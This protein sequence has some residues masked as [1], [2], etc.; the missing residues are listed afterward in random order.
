MT[1]K[2]LCRKCLPVLLSLLTL[3]GG[4]TFSSSAPARAEAG[5]FYVAPG[6]NCGAASPCYS[7][8]QAAVDA[9]AAGDEIRVATGVYSGV[10]TQ[11][12][13]SQVVYLA[14]DLSLR[15]GFTTA[16][17]TAPD[18]AANPTEI[19]AQT[20]G[21]ALFVAENVTAQV[22]G[23]L[24]TYGNA[25][26]L[27][28]HSDLGGEKDAGGGIYLRN[29]S[30]TLLDSQVLHS[31][32]TSTGLGGGLYAANSAVSVSNT[33]FE[34]NGS[35]NGGGACL[36]DSTTDI[37]DS[38]FI[39]NRVFSMNATGQGVTAQGGNFTFTGNTVDANINSAGSLTDGSLYIREATFLV[40]NNLVTNTI[41]D[42]TT[43]Y[44]SGISIQYASGTLSGNTVT[45]NR[46]LGV[47]VLAGEVTM[48]SNEIAYNTRHAP[49]NGAGVT[50]SP[51]PQGT[52]EFVLS[53]NYIHH[54]T[55]N[56]GT[57]SGAGANLSTREGNPALLAYNLIQ[58]NMAADGTALS[59]DGNGGGV[60]VS[61]DFATLI[62]NLIQRNFARGFVA[63]N[64]SHLGGLGG[65][66]Y[67]SGNA[68]LIN[69]IITNN[70]ARF[71]GSGVYVSGS[72]PYL[73]HNTIANNLYSESEDGSGVYAA[74]SAANEPGQPRLYNNIISGQKVGAYAARG[75]V[76]SIIFVENVLWHA[77]DADTGGSG[78]VFVNNPFSGDPLFVDAAAYDYHLLL[79]SAAI[80]HGMLAQI[81]L[82]I[83]R[84]PRIGAPDLGADEY[85]AP[86]AIRYV[87]LPLVDR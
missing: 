59:E 30:L 52:S 84:E 34:D 86:G 81:G 78:A 64:D 8:L 35:D 80:D 37:R 11:G 15:G 9:A 1:P 46:N 17:W 4:G 29:A 44:G 51:H 32:T 33:R 68:T 77:N 57:A 87:F 62:G 5:I 2:Q 27:G 76:S 65:G 67:I 28:G 54:N 73:Y 6:G 14:K 39:A 71:A 74:E 3:C 53:Y 79:G 12:G 50:F 72:T 36:I 63:P 31:Y 48:T 66:V 58:D 45:H 69:N 19:A 20:L 24:L 38:E 13:K 21:R 56:Y 43:R 41:A 49:G 47:A 26:G 10:N 23:F 22:E 85:W 42:G 82:D 16:N 25:T 40:Q 60:T 18:P 83:D 75:D 55:D 61:G 70:Q 7:N